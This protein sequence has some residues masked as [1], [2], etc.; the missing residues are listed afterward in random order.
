MIYLGKALR[1]SEDPPLL[2]GEAHFAADISFDGQLH[3]R[4]VRS[5]VA[6]GRLLGI[7]AGDALALP[8]VAAVWSGRDVA[9]LAPIDFRQVRLP[10][11]KPYRQPILAQGYV[12][13][14]GEPVAVL[15]AEDPYLAEDAADLVFADIEEGE[16][17]RSAT[18]RPG[19]FKIGSGVIA[20]DGATR[21]E[22]Y[23]GMAADAQAKL[24]DFMRL[25]K[26]R[27]EFAI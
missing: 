7:E 18:E 12:R 1:R 19:E 27:L 21:F 26:C 5:P 2:R 3:M 13:Y 22:R 10:G 24:D 11:L 4:V 17:I 9:D 23:A 16:P 8:G 15:F 14:V 6:F 25:G 20:S